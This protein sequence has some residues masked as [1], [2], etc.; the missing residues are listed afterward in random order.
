MDKNNELKAVR[1][2]TFTKGNQLSSHH[3]VDFV[4]QWNIKL[5]DGRI[6]QTEVDALP[7]S[8]LKMTHHHLQILQGSFVPSQPPPQP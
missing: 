7:D 8:S 5:K 4:I 3:H 2:V 1:Q 6:L